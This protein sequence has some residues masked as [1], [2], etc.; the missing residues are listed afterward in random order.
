M[1]ELLP[2]I[3][4]LRGGFLLDKSWYPQW[5]RPWFWATLMGVLIAEHLGLSG[6]E[7]FLCAF[8]VYVGEKFGWGR[9]LGEA[10]DGY[11]TADYE[12]WQVGI[13]KQPWIAL[14]F[15]G[16]LW[17][18]FPALSGEWKL[19][20]IFAVAMPLSVLIARRYQIER[21]NPWGSAEWFRGAIVGVGIYA[22]VA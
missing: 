5:I 9:P 18:A 3:D 4:R 13:L 22:A 16:A 2:L 19:I 8:G 17:G 1:L 14:T 21:G 15:R 11:S 10:L 7:Y 12:R 20:P 6:W